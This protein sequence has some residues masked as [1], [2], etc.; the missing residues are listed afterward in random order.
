MPL[1]AP[2]LLPRRSLG[3]GR[4]C[5]RCPS[6][7]RGSRSGRRTRSRSVRAAAARG[8]GDSPEACPS[9][10]V[11]RAAHGPGRREWP[12]PGRTCPPDPR[13]CPS[14]SLSEQL[15]I[16]TVVT[17]WRTRLD[18]PGRELHLGVVVG[19]EV[20]EARR[21]PPA[22]GVDA[23]RPGIHGERRLADRDDAPVLDAHVGAQAGPAP[24]IED[25]PARDDRVECVHHLRKD[26]SSSGASDARTEATPAPFPSAGTSQRL[27]VRRMF[28][29]GMPTST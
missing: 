29:C 6:R 14:A 15:P 9:P 18:E 4:G 11:P 1:H 23:R 13:A 19:V 25:R 24:S 10:C 27:T 21:H 20:D 5:A 3:A 7:A 26:S 8:G 16:E 17:P 28:W 2:E 12:R 22:G